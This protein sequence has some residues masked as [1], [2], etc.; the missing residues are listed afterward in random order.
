[1]S[2]VLFL[3]G[4]GHAPIR[5]LP[6]R[7]ALRRRGEPF[8]VADLPY[9][10]A[11]SFDGLLETLS[12]QVPERLDRKG[13]V[14]ASGIGALVVLALRARGAL[15][16][17]PVVLQG[18]VLW[19]LEHRWFPRVMRVS[20]MPRLLAAAFRLGV[21]RRRFAARH[22]L[23]EHPRDFVDAFFEGYRDAGAF[24]AW[25]DWLR[26]GLLRRLEGEIARTPGALDD[27]VAWWGARDGVVSVEEL[28]LTERAL[29]VDVPLRIFPQWGHYPM[30]D[31]PDGWVG[32]VEGVVA[33]AR[34]LS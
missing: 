7:D 6:A 30:I 21:V 1:M 11:T 5:L 34:A 32:E 24:A 28:R 29:G 8:T 15:R 31:D 4:N 23:R 16:D 14:Y 19:G 33:T 2:D 3:G 20:P 17:H 12:R 10:P 9:P 25:F 26:P 27:V 18:G 22:F 13:V